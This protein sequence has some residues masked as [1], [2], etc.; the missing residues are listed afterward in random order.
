MARK[1]T[2]CHAG[3]SRIAA[4]LSPTNPAQPMSTQTARDHRKPWLRHAD[5]R[6]ALDLRAE[7]Q[8]PIQ[9]TADAANPWQG[10]VSTLFLHTQCGGEPSSPAASDRAGPISRPAQAA[11]SL[12]RH[13]IQVNNVSTA[14]HGLGARPGPDP[15]AP[16]PVRP[17]APKNSAYSDHGYAAATPTEISV[18]IVAAPRRALTAAARWKGQAPHTA[19]GEASPA[20][21][22]RDPGQAPG[23]VLSRR[24][25][26][27]RRPCPAPRP[28]PAPSE[29]PHW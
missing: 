27:N 23:G 11:P 6:R 3:S 7:V 10:A 26:G 17:A 24:R 25:A 13:Q 28:P 12:H 22:S 29:P 8:P 1:G 21:L 5:I 20:D 14:A 2:V 9:T 18:S 4:R 19:T 16:R 15:G